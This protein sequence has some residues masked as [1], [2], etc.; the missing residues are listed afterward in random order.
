MS[1]NFFGR[2]DKR[3]SSW[4]Y[5]EPS[6]FSYRN[7]FVDNVSKHKKHKRKFKN[8]RT[9]FEHL[10]DPITKYTPWQKKVNE[11]YYTASENQYTLGNNPSN[12]PLDPFFDSIDDNYINQE[13]TVESF[14][15]TRTEDITDV[16]DMENYKKLMKNPP[17][18]NPT[19][20]KKYQC[21]ICYDNEKCIV[22]IPC[23]HTYCWDCTNK[24]LKVKNKC[25]VCRKKITDV[26]KLF[27]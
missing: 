11:G 4:K 27:D 13:G 1:D 9:I 24:S 15:F 6:Y 2:S 19:T 5:Y 20:N 23:G 12:R 26:N 21:G 10:N 17:K 22:L 18:D 25:P 16:K 8:V 3:E 7:P 14:S